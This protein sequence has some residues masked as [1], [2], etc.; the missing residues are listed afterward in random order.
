MVDNCHLYNE[1]R[2]PHLPPMADELYK[3]AELSV[4]AINDK[5]T[6]LEQEISNPKNDS[7]EEDEDGLPSDL[8]DEEGPEEEDDD[9]DVCH[10]LVLI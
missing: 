4:E 6:A 5:L 3:V 10:L 1:T 9:D 8:E 7:N 2:N